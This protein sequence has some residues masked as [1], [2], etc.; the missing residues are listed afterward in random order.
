MSIT[1]H[2]KLMITTSL[3]MFGCSWAMGQKLVSKEQP[4]ADTLAI[5]AAGPSNPWDTFYPPPPG[6]ELV[7]PG[8]KPQPEASAM[9][10]TGFTVQL[11][12][13]K[14]CDTSCHKPVRTAA[15]KRK[16]IR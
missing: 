13:A 9:P 16:Q 10:T 12:A 6:A 5:S 14:G 15:L 11:T 1:I 4:H 3:L 8:T 7:V 2:R